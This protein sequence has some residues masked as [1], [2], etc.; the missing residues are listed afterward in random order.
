M[1]MNF[2]DLLFNSWNNIYMF[3]AHVI[4][5]TQFSSN[6][7]ILAIFWR[8]DFFHVTQFA[9][10]CVCYCSPWNIFLKKS[11]TMHML[12]LVCSTPGPMS[13]PDTASNL[14]V[15]WDH[16]SFIVGYHDHFS[17][18]SSQRDC[19]SQSSLSHDGN[20][21]NQCGRRFLSYRSPL[22]ETTHVWGN[23]LLNNIPS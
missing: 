14:S 5:V 3:E 17:S 18:V 4:Y 13:S 21:A 16:R 15:Q 23:S 22:S 7:Y 12:F 2:D 9:K 10:I 11:P 19:V 8:K 20:L 6:I 1:S